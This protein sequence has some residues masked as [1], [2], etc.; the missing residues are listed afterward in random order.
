MR[1]LPN[2]LSS[3]MKQ[4]VC[5]AMAIA[6]NPQLVIADEPANAA[7]EVVQRLL[8]ETMMDTQERLRDSVILVGQSIGVLAQFVSRI[9][10]M[11]AGRVAEISDIR[12]MFSNPLHPYTQMLIQT[13]SSIA[14]HRPLFTLPGLPP[15]LRNLPPG[16]PFHPR[17][18]KI[19]PICKQLIPPLRRVGSERVVACHLYRTE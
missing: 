7:D 18:P 15:S 11:Y 13:I 14:Q 2:D 1:L 16:C 9:C 6:L 4:R 5:V 3:S 12:A 8:V 10:V 19:M 17:C